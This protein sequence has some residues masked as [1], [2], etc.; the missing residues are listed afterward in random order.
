[1]VKLVVIFALFILQDQTINMRLQVRSH[2]EK[3]AVIIETAQKRFGLYGIE[4]T[5]MREIA[6]DLNMT[7]GSLYYYFPG[8]E[9]LYK[10]VVEKE[11]SE[12]IRVL[13][14]D[15]KNLHDPVEG[16][17]K[18]VVN[19][20][21]YFKTMVNLSRL[22]AESFSEYKPLIA[23]SMSKFRENEKKI[24]MDFLEKG[25]TQGIFMVEDTTETADLFLDLLRGL[26]S[27]VL[28]DKKLLIIDDDEFRI[29]A[30]KAMKFTTIFINGIKKN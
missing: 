12:F 16:I 8:K 9:N 15:M 5:T 17:K 24:I 1:M 25:N 26:R 13:Y 14:N 18:Y 23:D 30:G 3:A 20:L 21:Y 22:R 4:K 29:M 19:R 11:Q 10:A 2:Q 6:G 7:K 28:T 27:A